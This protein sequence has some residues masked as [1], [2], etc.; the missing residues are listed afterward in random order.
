MI[1]YTDK[2]RQMKEVEINKEQEDNAASA[3]SVT[4]DHNLSR[5]PSSLL[6]RRSADPRLRTSGMSEESKYCFIY[7]I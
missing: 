7:D 6:R 4:A 5:N 3:Y 2:K 1:S